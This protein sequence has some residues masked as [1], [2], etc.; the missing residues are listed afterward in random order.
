MD[1]LTTA[2]LLDIN[3]KLRANPPIN[4]IAA[5]SAPFKEQIHKYEIEKKQL[6]AL[7]QLKE[8]KLALYKEHFNKNIFRYKLA[9]G[10]TS[11]PERL[12]S[13]PFWHIASQNQPFKTRLMQEHEIFV[14]WVVSQKAFKELAIEYGKQLG[15]SKD[16]VVAKSREKERGVLNNEFKS[17]NKT[18]I[19]DIN[20]EK[21]HG[22]ELA[23][24]ILSKLKKK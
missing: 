14:D 16:D 2:L 23:G 11:T 6:E 20:L 3:T 22:N 9:N 4:T 13:E 18:N 1:I 8:D 7:N 24:T 5:E 15:F 19:S 10:S 21:T 17:E 12:L